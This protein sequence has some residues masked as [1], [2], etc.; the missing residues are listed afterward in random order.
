MIPPITQ[1]P[2]KFKLENS[3]TA[4]VITSHAGMAWVRQLIESTG[5]GQE[6]K[7][8][9]LKKQGYDDA[10]ILQALI[11]LL[12]SGAQHLS[13]WE[14]L[15]QDAGFERIFGKCPS[16]DTLE[17]YLRKFNLSVPSRESEAGQVGWVQ[18][19]EGSHCHMIEQ[20]Y[21]A[22]GCPKKLTFDCDAT[23]IPS[24]KEEA[25]YCYEKYKAYQ[26][27]LV[28]CP[29]LQLVLAYEFR[30]GNVS[31]QEGYQRIIE[32][33]CSLFPKDTKIT[34]RSDSAAYINEFMD[35][36]EKRRITYFIT[37]DQSESMKEAIGRVSEWVPFTSHGVDWG[38]SHALLDYVPTAKTKAEL[39]L[40]L[41]RRN[42]LA[43]RR[44]KTGGQPELFDSYQVIVTNA[45]RQTG[46]W[47]I[48][49]HRGRCGTVE[50]CN[51]QLKN[52]LGL[53][54]MPS[55]SFKVNTAWFALGCL[56]HN[57]LRFA[58]HFVLPEQFKKYGIK[59]LRFWLINQAALV[60]NTGRQL[61]IRLSRNQLFFNSWNVIQ[62]RLAALSS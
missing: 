56:V 60:I 39:E 62:G 33:C 19:L 4:P 21:Q 55:G 22:A 5:L 27:L 30:D 32:R 10:L 54:V 16:V 48:K 2:L 8:I 61:I 47:V 17:R 44:P 23:L 46:V 52:H 14:L 9:G 41:R 45:D 20:A 42:Y 53:G 35:W 11:L 59:R 50:Y 6:L 31:P 24:D 37:A 15:S 25:L 51:D 40:R 57:L 49:Q 1:K 7:K 12:S 38:E 13:D 18:E 3:S 58:Q 29:E 34:L 26:P 36:M 28:Y 43:V